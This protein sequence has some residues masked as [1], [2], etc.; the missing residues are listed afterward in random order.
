[1]TYPLGGR[2]AHAQWTS[3]SLYCPFSAVSEVVRLHAPT[4]A[5]FESKVEVCLSF[6]YESLPN[7]EVG[8]SKR[9]VVARPMDE[10][11]ENEVAQ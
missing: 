11:F 5:D 9:D 3:Q 1:M 4:A 6:G 10:A 8:K 2:R 7:A